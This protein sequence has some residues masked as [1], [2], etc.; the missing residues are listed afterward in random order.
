MQSRDDV[1]VTPAYALAWPTI[2]ALRDLG[3]SARIGE[4]TP[5]VA[6]LL[7][8]NEEQQAVPHAGGS[9]TELEYRL[10]W[11]RT[12]LKNMGALENSARGVW[13]LTE[14]GR[15]I[16]ETEISRGG[17]RPLVIEGAPNDTQSDD[18]LEEAQPPERIRPTDGRSSYSVSS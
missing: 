18:H 8:L 15:T 11:A 5:A 17:S 3:G 16:G 10:A 7:G 12:M 13:S 4:I 2:Q 1:F 14:L 9:R 6:D